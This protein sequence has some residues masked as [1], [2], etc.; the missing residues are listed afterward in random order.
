[1]TSLR[2]VITTGFE[3]DDLWAEIGTA[4]EVFAAV[5]LEP[6]GR[7]ILRLFK[8]IERTMLLVDLSEFQAVVDDACQRLTKMYPER[9]PQ[10]RAT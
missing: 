8:G 3:S 1:M 4:D 10:P 6:D 7:F 2:Y 9:V 5:S